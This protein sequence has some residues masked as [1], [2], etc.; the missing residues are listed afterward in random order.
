MLKAGLYRNHVG[1]E[2]RVVGSALWQ[3]ASPQAKAN[4]FTKNSYEFLSTRIYLA[5]RD[6]GSLGSQRYLV[7]EEDM[8]EVGYELIEEFEAG[9]SRG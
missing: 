3:L 8:N 4:P 6:D 5:V 2:L 7:T 9:E 1:G